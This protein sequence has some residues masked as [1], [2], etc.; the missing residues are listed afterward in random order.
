MAKSNPLWLRSSAGLVV[1]LLLPL[2]WNALNGAR[3]TPV[4]ILGALCSAWYCGATQL[5][6][7]LSKHRRLLTAALIYPLLVGLFEPD[8]NVPRFTLVLFA[9]AYATITSLALVK[10]VRAVGLPTLV[11]GILLTGAIMT[12]FAFALLRHLG[13]DAIVNLGDD[14][15]RM[16]T[17]ETIAFFGAFGCSNFIFYFMT[18]CSLSLA[19]V[20]VVFW[21]VAWPYRIVYPALAL[22]ATYCNYAIATRTVVFVFLL[23]CI[24]LAVLPIF[25]TGI[26]LSRRTLISL[27]I[28]LC[29]S[30]LSA[31]G[32]NS[33]LVTE[34]LVLRLQRSQDDI[35]LFLWPEG[36]KLTLLH[37]VGGGIRAFTLH[38]W[39]H[40]HI[41]DVGL[42]YGIPGALAVGYVYFAALRRTFRLYRHLSLYSGA[43][44]LFLTVTS[45]AI[46]AM[47]VPPHVPTYAFVLILG[48]VA[49]ELT[50]TTQRQPQ[51]RT[52]HTPLPANPIT[53]SGGQ[54]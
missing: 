28:I 49:S 47:T 41:L 25:H 1:L 26:S 22:L 33:Q 10:I 29:V 12:L 30:V 21:Q 2:V 48:L 53:A 11:H 9:T 23:V 14:G 44:V 34:S 16:A 54:V 15:A 7:Y 52:G 8:P 19:G 45:L 42:S 3:S 6:S 46:L 40:N 27:A 24:F 31:V 4:L 13:V 37:P 20:A 35:R 18:L 36:F 39:A 32:W 5:M 17:G 51:F 38:T 50:A 43:A